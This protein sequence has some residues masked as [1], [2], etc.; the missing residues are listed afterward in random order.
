MFQ[1]LSDVHLEFIRPEKIPRLLRGLAP[2]L[3]LAGDISSY[4]CKLLPKFLEIASKRYEIVFW[5]L[6][7]HEYY[8]PIE[9]LTMDEIYQS[10]KTMCSQYSN[11]HILDNSSYVYRDIEFI[12]STLWSHIPDGYD[13]DSNNF[14][15]IYTDKECL[16]TPQY[17]NSLHAKAVEYIQNRLLNLYATHQS[18]IVVTHFPPKVNGTSAPHH[19]GSQSNVAYASDLVFHRENPS[20]RCWCYGHTHHN[21]EQNVPYRLISNQYGYSG[22]QTGIGFNPLK[23][24]DKYGHWLY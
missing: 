11:I 18:A 5:V 9:H 20:V 12:G 13:V 7:N 2:V 14:K 10:L 23:V 15:A 24:Y 19:I 3:V 16:L 8:S 17:A 4:N 22:N 21:S 6:G 1:L